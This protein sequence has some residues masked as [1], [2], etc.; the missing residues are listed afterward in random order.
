[1]ET[2]RESV[3]YTKD[4]IKRF[5]RQ[6]NLKRSLSSRHMTMIAIGGSIGTGLFVASGASFPLGGPGGALLAF[7][8]SGFTLFFVMSSLA[9]M[10]TFIP[11]AGSFNSF[12]ERFVDPALGFSVAY[13]YWYSWITAS[14]NDIVA[15]GLVMQ[16]WLPN[17]K[18]VIWNFVVF[19][20]V[21]LLNL[22]GSR[23]YGEAE[24]WMSLIKVIA[25][26]IFIIVGV[27]VASGI[28]GG[29]KYGFKMWSYKEAPF[30][31][32]ALG[33][34]RVFI[35][36]NYSFQ[37]AEIVGIT[38]G[39]SKNP[40]KS[41][42]RAIRTIFWRIL[43]FY[44][45]SIFLI[46]LIMPYDDPDLLE[47]GAENVAYSPMVIVLR[48][49]GI[50]P[51]AHIMNAVILT[52]V[53]SAANSGL[54]LTSRSL[55]SISIEGKGPKVLGKV[56]EKG[57][58]LFSILFCAIVIMGF[59]PIALIGDQ[60]VYTWFLSL[61]G[62]SGTISWIVIIY[63]HYRFRRGYILQGYNLDDLPYLAL[64][65][66]FGQFFSFTLFSFILLAQGYYTFIGAPF[67]ASGFF[68][69]YIGIPIFFGMWILYKMIRKT[70]VIKL[71]EIDYETENYISL[72]FE[73]HRHEKSSMKETLLSFFS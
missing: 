31:N 12:A 51:A 65:Y 60:T 67:D 5:I 49:A 64:F 23:I 48:I 37:G 2:T 33:F 50:K 57:L 41:V 58:P 35:I 13:N 32:G 44:V 24:F 56:T 55:Y 19:I 16:Y 14:A 9:E 39:E 36:S 59:F 17:V 26:I 54:F 63:T 21:L 72:G 53:I 15:A 10:S 30:V 45:L 6:D 69:T 40:S 1:M 62:V 38:A 18:P 34:L 4:G 20:I 3:E 52:S 27:L 22:F 29:T 46:G 47:S 61:S 42:P 28:I 8:V 11:V 71:H 66:P 73:N 43:L 68:Q 70:K 7:I 25:I